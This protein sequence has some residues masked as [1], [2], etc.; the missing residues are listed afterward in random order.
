MNAILQSLKCAICMDVLVEPRTLPCG[1]AFCRG[2]LQK[3][4]DGAGNLKCPLDNRTFN[5]PGG[6]AGN[7][8]RNYQLEAA[9]ESARIGASLPC[10]DHKDREAKV[11]CDSCNKAVCTECMLQHVSHGILR[12]ANIKVEDEAQKQQN[13]KQE[14][15]TRK[16]TKQG[17]SQA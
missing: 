12:S 13:Q 11:V 17:E 9:I 14:T 7:L 8:M 4:I 10:S 3:L 1:H 2:C 6:D 16:D 15:L 5:V